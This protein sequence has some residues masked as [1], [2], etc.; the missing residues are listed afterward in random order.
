MVSKK[1]PIVI[2]GAGSIGERY[3]QILQS[4]GYHNLH[5]FRQRLLPLRTIE[6]SSFNT[7]TKLEEIDL[8]QPEAAIICTPTFQHVAQSIFCLE[9]KIPVLVEKPLGHNPYQ[10]ESLSRLLKNVNTV[11]FQV[12]YMLR[13]HPYFIKVKSFIDQS[14]LGK[15]L[16]IK[17]HWGEHLPDWHPW[18]DYRTSY[19]ISKKMGGGAALTLSHDVDLCNW[20]SGSPVEK[21]HRMSNFQPEL[22]E[23]VDSGSDISIRYQNGVTASCHVNFF[24]R[25]PYRNYRF[26]FADGTV[27]FDFTQNTLTTFRPEIAPSSQSTLLGTAIGL[28]QSGSHN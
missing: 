1:D 6:A 4:M 5:V 3:I 10:L 13:Y 15:L 28:F 21:W 2:M 23:E 25:V 24:E 11:H 7:F 14:H 9:R 22:T 19:A 26:I 27:N 17:T 20:L 8:I 18:E 16:A 12:A